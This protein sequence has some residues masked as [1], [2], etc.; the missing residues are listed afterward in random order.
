MREHNF[1][2]KKD[3]TNIY[4]VQEI[5]NQP[6]TAYSYFMSHE[7]TI[8]YVVEGERLCG[9]ISFGDLERY[10]KSERTV[11]TYNDSFSFISDKNDFE[12]AEIIFNKYKSIFEIP[13]ICEDEFIG[14]LHREKQ[15][16]GDC[17]KTPERR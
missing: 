5:Y 14:T 1:V 10:Y 6:E 7:S 3:L 11:F 2:E 12:S 16:G 13:V 4:N 15:C 17:P 8:I 9:I